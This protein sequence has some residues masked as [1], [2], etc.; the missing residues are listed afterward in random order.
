MK[1][2]LIDVKANHRSYP[3]YD[4]IKEEEGMIDDIGKMIE[5]GFDEKMVMRVYIYLK[6]NSIEEIKEYLTSEE[7]KYEHKF[8]S[9]IKYRNN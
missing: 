4:P 2:N 6:P 5:E 8:I 3:Q 1:D 9:N 7:G